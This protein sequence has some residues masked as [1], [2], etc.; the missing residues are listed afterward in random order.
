M[1]KLTRWGWTPR[2][3]SLRSPAEEVGKNDLKGGLQQPSTSSEVTP[4]EEQDASAPLQGDSKE[5]I[6]SISSSPLVPVFPKEV[7]SVLLPPLPEVSVVKQLI[8]LSNRSR[9]TSGEGV[10]ETV[11]P[12][13]VGDAQIISKS[14]RMVFFVL[15]YCYCY[16][17]DGGVA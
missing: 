12:K 13:L 11:D 14:L 9:E 2:R 3:K 7:E 17:F 16:L 4:S 8:A 5:I 6:S 1:Q 10:W 15:L